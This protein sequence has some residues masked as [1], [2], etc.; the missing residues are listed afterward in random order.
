MFWLFYTLQVGTKYFFNADSEIKFSIHLLNVISLI[1]CVVF[2]INFTFCNFIKLWIYA[3]LQKRNCFC[4]IR[5]ISLTIFLFLYFAYFPLIFNVSVE[6]TLF[7]FSLSN[8]I[9]DLCVF[10][11]SRPTN[12]KTMERITFI[13]P[14][15]LQQSHRDTPERL[16]G[17]IFIIESEWMLARH[18][19]ARKQF[20]S[21]CKYSL[22]VW[23][24]IL[25]TP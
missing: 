12:T 4:W 22:F 20:S 13:L 18:N 14:Q 24:S 19:R 17:I 21:E 1:S 9:N 6:I 15:W 3:S 7:C 5:C 2:I 25:N 16:R 8:S 10:L 11:H 23:F